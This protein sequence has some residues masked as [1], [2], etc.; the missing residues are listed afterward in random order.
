MK[1]NKIINGI[2][3]VATLCTIVVIFVLIE[4]TSK[5]DGIKSPMLSIK[6]DTHKQE[7]TTY[8]DVLPKVETIESPKLELI[9]TE[10]KP[11]QKNS[12]DFSKLSYTESEYEN[13]GKYVKLNWMPDSNIIKDAYIDAGGTHMEYWDNLV[14][15]NNNKVEKSVDTDSSKKLQVTSDN[16]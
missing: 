2:L 4:K 13:A 12:L 7:I 15:E 9:N 14:D 8:G 6:S 1:N 16:N 3:S 10:V 5:S 11:A